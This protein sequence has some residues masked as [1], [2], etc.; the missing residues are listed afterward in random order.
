MLQFLAG[1]HPPFQRQTRRP[2]RSDSRDS[3]AS[4]QPE[5]GSPGLGDSQPRFFFGRQLDDIDDT[6]PGEDAV[7]KEPAISNG[8]RSVTDTRAKSRPSA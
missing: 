4:P 1:R 6:F 2:P 3:G 8:E 7:K 5:H